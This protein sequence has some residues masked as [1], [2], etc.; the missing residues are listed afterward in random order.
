VRVILDEAKRLLRL[1]INAGGVG[2]SFK[3]FWGGGNPVRMRAILGAR[4]G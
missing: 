3:T 2:F 1:E 4:K